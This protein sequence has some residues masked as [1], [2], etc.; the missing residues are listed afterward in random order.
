M[1]VAIKTV[2]PQNISCLYGHIANREV[3]TSI[4]REV[5]SCY[6]QL[7]VDLKWSSRYSQLREDRQDEVESGGFVTTTRRTMPLL[8]PTVKKHPRTLLA[9]PPRLL[10]VA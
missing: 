8:R 5:V 9:E 10:R 2:L 7:R 1:P 4:R 3:V 6:L